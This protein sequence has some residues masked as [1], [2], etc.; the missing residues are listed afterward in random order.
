MENK[1]RLEKQIKDER[2]RRGWSQAEL[3]RKCGVQR[4]HISKI[5][6]DITR[7]SIEL[8]LKIFD[9]LCIDIILYSL[10]EHNEQHTNDIKST[11]EKLD[12]LTESERED[13]K[14]RARAE[15]IEECGGKPGL[16]F[17]AMIQ[18]RMNKLYSAEIGFPG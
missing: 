10:E 16:I 6:Q 9:I 13:L 4:N 8:L 17:P 2:K 7:C 11:Y 15:L 3:G 5:E 18:D 12:R 14:E 1:Q